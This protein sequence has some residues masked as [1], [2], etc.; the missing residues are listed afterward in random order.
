[1][2]LDEN[3]EESSNQFLRGIE[4]YLSDKEENEITYPTPP[5]SP[6]AAALMSATIQMPVPALAH[7]EKFEAS[8]VRKIT[9]WEA[10]FLAGA[11]DK[12]IGTWEGKPFRR[13]TLQ[14]FIRSKA[15]FQAISMKGNL[16]ASERVKSVIKQ[17]L[18]LSLL[19]RNELPPPPKW[20]HELKHHELGKKFKEAEIEH[21]KSHKP[22]ATWSKIAR[23]DA[24]GAQ[25]L[26]CMWV[27]VYKFDKH[28][29]LLK[30]KARLVVRGDQQNGI[31][32]GDT[33]AATLAMRSFRTFMAICAKFGLEMKQY[34]AVNA[35]VH[36]DLKETVFMKRPPGYGKEGQILKLNK[37]LYGL[38]TSPL[39][40]QKAF[41]K[42]LKDL[43]FEAVPHEPCCM[44]KD[45]ILI[46][47]YV[48]DIVIA[49]DRKNERAAQEIMKRLQKQY[50]ITGGDDLQWFL[51]I[52]V[53]RNKEKKLIWLSQASYI[54]KIVKLADSKP[55]HETPMSRDELLPHEKQAEPHIVHSYQRKVGSLMYAAVSTRIDVSFAVSRLSR[56]LTN[57][58]PA[59]HRAA[60]RVLHYLKKNQHLALQLGGGEGFRVASDAS[61]ADNSIDRKSSQ[62]YVMTLFGG[63]TGWQANKQDTVTTSTT[64]AELLALSQ[65]AKEG[66]Y[67]QRLLKELN[68]NVATAPLRLECDNKQTIGLIEKDIATLKTKLRHVDIHHH[69]LRQEHQAGRVKVVY[70]PTKTMIANGLTK[71]LGKGDFEDFLSQIGMR[72][73]S[74]LLGQS[75]HTEDNVNLENLMEELDF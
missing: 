75:T 18:D 11:R 39:L 66:L 56:F 35:F 20:H 64:E 24:D 38:R 72:D 5:E 6:P 27:Y 33:Y 12:E 63:V 60:D 46:F 1:M 48:D 23:K 28:G 37:A 17:G 74:E 62:A 3:V 53:L 16:V 14:R 31:N 10:S 19:H 58:S 68:V 29:K 42:S 13:S 44:T 2:L 22:M 55:P 32:H 47:F 71:A 45:G 4:D 41:T 73:C 8:H 9:P 61:F 36:A 57:P 54:D 25:I 67:V 59:H 7:E 34:D 65:A 26:D 70:M 52:R 49:Y 69:W 40:W 50:K 43:G 21:L 30:C 51:G 15:A